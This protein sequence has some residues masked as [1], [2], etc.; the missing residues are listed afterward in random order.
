MSDMF[1]SPP[2]ETKY[3]DAFERCWKVHS[4]GTKK[5]AYAAGVKA[6]WSAGNWAWLERYLECRHKDD[7]KWLEGTY[8]PHLSSII[9]G[10]RWA[11][12]Y[13]RKKVGRQTVSPDHVESADEIA[14]KL[15]AQQDRF[16]EATAQAETRREMQ[17]KG[18]A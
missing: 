6:G 1:P 15:R 8:I 9:N 3:S 14:A 5:T 2:P 13:T 11:D 12:S 7:E 4:V 18:L 17:R 10:E 16:A